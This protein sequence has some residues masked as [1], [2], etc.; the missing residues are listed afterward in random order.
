ME[1]VSRIRNTNVGLTPNHEFA[2]QGQ[3]HYKR[4]MIYTNLTC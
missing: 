2:E 1:M 3:G 4:G